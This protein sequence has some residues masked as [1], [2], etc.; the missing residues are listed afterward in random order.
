MAGAISGTGREQ[1][2]GT[3]ARS[4]QHPCLSRHCPP[5]LLFVRL[6][7]GR[8]LWRVGIALIAVSFV[9]QIASLAFWLPLEIYQM[10]TLGH[11]TFVVALRFKEHRSLRFGQDGCVGIEQRVHDTGC[12]GLRSHHMLEFVPF[13]LR[14]VGA[15]PKWVVDAAFAVGLAG[16]V[17]LLLCLTRLQ[18][19]M[20]VSASQARHL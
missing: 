8:W 4:L 11:P 1:S 16:I 2:S 12:L 5:P 7:L 9:I 19:M 3:T 17:G 13:L 15:A 6:P 18:R 10:E 14:R 20:K